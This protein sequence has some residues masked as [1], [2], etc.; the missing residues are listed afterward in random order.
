[1]RD[2]DAFNGGAIYSVNKITLTATR[3]VFF[4]NKAKN[5]GGV[6]AITNAAYTVLAPTVLTFT[7]CPSIDKNKADYGG[8]AYYDNNYAEL[9]IIDSSVTN[10][11]AYKRS[12]FIEA[13]EMN[14][15]TIS[16]SYIADF[17]APLTTLMHSVARKLSMT[18][19]DSNIV[20]SNFYRDW[21]AY[22]LINTTTVPKNE[23]HTNF[24][25]EA[26]K[27]VSLSKNNFK[28]CGGSLNG[29]VFW[30]T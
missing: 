10:H 28:M 7:S 9:R 29:G 4:N 23:R 27:I 13:Y 14:L 5:N 12:A 21:D 1:M 3:T 11:T 15:F 22:L 2:N 25:L 8:F 30:L 24:Y 26:S 19:S 6:L 17:S 20:C 16:N 18:I